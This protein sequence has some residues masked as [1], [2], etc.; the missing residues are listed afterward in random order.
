MFTLSPGR[1]AEIV[2]SGVNVGSLAS[3]AARD[4][5]WWEREGKMEWRSS[6]AGCRGTRGTCSVVSCLSETSRIAN[7]SSRLDSDVEELRRDI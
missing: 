2:F 3:P 6:G 5:D 4:F 1:S 7:G